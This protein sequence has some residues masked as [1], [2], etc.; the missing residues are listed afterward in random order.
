MKWAVEE[1]TTP[2]KKRNKNL[3][4]ERVTEEKMEICEKNE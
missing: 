2:A 4:L 1:N 3:N